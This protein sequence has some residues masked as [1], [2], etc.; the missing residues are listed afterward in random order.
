MNWRNECIAFPPPVAWINCIKW[1]EIILESTPEK[2]IQFCTNDNIDAKVVHDKNRCCAVFTEPQPETHR[3]SSEGMAPLDIKFDLVGNLSRNSLHAKTETFWG[4]YWCQTK[5]AT[6]AAC[7][8]DI[9]HS[10]HG[11]HTLN[12]MTPG[13]VRKPHPLIWNI[14][15][16]RNI[17]IQLYFYVISYLSVNS[18]V[19]FIKHYKFN[20]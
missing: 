9:F 12:E 17:K 1:S 4:T 14:S 7:K 8:R 13:R 2:P 6:E 5:S 15:L 11:V 16:H 20:H 19:N 18:I 10:K 3:Q